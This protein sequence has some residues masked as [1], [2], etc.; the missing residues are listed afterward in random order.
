MEQHAEIVIDVE[1]VGKGRPKFARQGN[2]V[3]TYTP[4]KTAEYENLIQTVYRLTAKNEQYK[5]VYFPADTP[6]SVH[7]RTFYGIPK[8]TGKAKAEEMLSGKI[9][10]LKKPDL[11]NICKI[12]YDALN[13]I[14][15]AD[16]KQ[17][18]ELS[19]RKFYSRNPR[20]EITIKELL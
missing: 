9:V 7:I 18:A 17:I 19:C 6:V 4:E 1:P 8:H 5:T 13:G 14:A 20:I 15:Y 2:Y 16:D 12:V 11:D 10:P 3:K